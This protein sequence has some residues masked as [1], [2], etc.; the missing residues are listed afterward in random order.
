MVMLHNSLALLTDVDLILG[1]LD[2]SLFPGLSSDIEVHSG[3]RNDQS[4]YVHLVLSL[5]A[6]SNSSPPSQ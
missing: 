3:F 1:G 5:Y 6:K 2:S 4:Q